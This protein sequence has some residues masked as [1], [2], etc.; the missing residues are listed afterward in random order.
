MKEELKLSEDEWG[1]KSLAGE[2]TFAV[3]TKLLLFAW[4]RNELWWVKSPEWATKHSYVAQYHHL[5]DGGRQVIITSGAVLQHCIAPAV[6]EPDAG[7]HV[8]IQPLTPS[9]LYRRDAHAVGLVAVPTGAAESRRNGI[10]CL[11]PTH[12]NES[13]VPFSRALLNSRGGH[14]VGWAPI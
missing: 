2:F 10:W 6:Y 1:R 3:P 11:K 14:A 9:V 12:M 13:L 7:V 4:F 8:E 5:R